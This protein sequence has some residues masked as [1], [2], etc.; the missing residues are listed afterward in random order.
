MREDFMNVVAEKVAFQ[1]PLG[2]V[3]A[4]KLIL[5]KSQA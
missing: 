3:L 4:G 1:N 5:F 2:P